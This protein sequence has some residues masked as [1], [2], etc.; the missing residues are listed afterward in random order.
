M[1]WVDSVRQKH[2][3][4]MPW[5]LLRPR[6]LQ[7]VT[8]G[9]WRDVPRCDCTRRVDGGQ[10]PYLE[11]PQPRRLVRGILQEGRG[12]D[13]PAPNPVLSLPQALVTF[14]PF[15][16]HGGATLLT[17]D[18]YC[19]LLSLPATALVGFATTSHSG[20]PDLPRPR[21]ADLPGCFPHVLF[22]FLTALSP[23]P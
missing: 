7:R 22:I 8:S 6:V 19:P 15:P 5:T 9:H 1:P 14:W 18:T 2:E 12:S 23:F 17:W 13:S 16:W 11:A 4:T 20:S 10:L 21:P 3:Y